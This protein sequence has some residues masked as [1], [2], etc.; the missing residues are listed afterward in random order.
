MATQAPTHSRQSR[1]QRV[2]RFA[3][4]VAGHWLLVLAS[5][6]LAVVIVSTYLHLPSCG[7]R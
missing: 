3:R 4:T 6:T 7:G 5:H 2:L 1:P